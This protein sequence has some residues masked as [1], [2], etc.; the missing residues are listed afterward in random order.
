MNT[1]NRGFFNFLA[2][3]PN[4]V[5]IGLLVFVI[6]LLLMVFFYFGTKKGNTLMGHLRSQ[7]G[8]YVVAF[9]VSA[10]PVITAMISKVPG[11]GAAIFAF[12]II[13]SSI[14][15][16]IFRGRRRMNWLFG[17]SRYDD[18]GFLDAPY[19]RGYDPIAIENNIRNNQTRRE[20]EAA[21][22]RAEVYLQP[23][24]NPMGD[25]T[26][27]NR[28]CTLTY[29]C[30][31]TRC[32]YNCSALEADKN[33]DIISFMAIGLRDKEW[34]DDCFTSI[35]KVF[36][37]DTNISAL[38]TFFADKRNF[39]MTKMDNFRKQTAD[40]SENASDDNANTNAV[41]VNTAPEEELSKLPGINV[42][43]AKRIVSYRSERGGFKSVDDFIKT[44]GIKSQ[45]AKKIN[46]LI[47][48]SKIEKK[49]VVENKR[50]LDI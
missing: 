12:L 36:S 29:T 3:L 30:S 25:H 23:Y 17:R 45:F 43:L 22:R 42:V 32:V 40:N 39:D 11:L 46:K 28:F 8:W 26:L 37:Y 34:N 27:Q 33:A 6:L 13:I 49:T 41:D 38:A 24:S 47:T 16:E 35:L 1:Y 5:L 21:L 15:A 19:Y 2:G 4:N 48:A 18:Y 14:A 7:W 31:G 50:V 9:L 20:R 10:G 44:M